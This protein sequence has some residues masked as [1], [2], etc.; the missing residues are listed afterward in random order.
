MTGSRSQG[1]EMKKKSPEPK[2][3][4]KLFKNIERE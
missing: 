1:T 4:V 2:N 3:T